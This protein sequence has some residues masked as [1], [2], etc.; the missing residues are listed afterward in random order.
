MKNYRLH[1]IMVLGSI[2]A[3]SCKN[4]N[5]PLEEGSWA[6]DSFGNKIEAWFELDST[7]IGRS[8]IRQNLDVPWE[9]TWGPDNNI[10]FT[11]QGGRVSRLNPE[12]GEVQVL[13]EI[14]EVFRKRTT[15]LLGMAIH[16][17]FQNNPHVFLNYTERRKGTI[18]SRLV[19][20]EYL[21]DTLVNPRKLLEI[22][23]H[24]AHN[25]SRL[26][27]SPDHKLI[28]ATGDIG[29][30]VD[31]AQNLNSLNGKLLRLNLD[32]TIPP[33]NPIPGSPVWSW[34]Q[35]NVQGLVYG[36]KG[37]AYTSEHGDAT[38]DEINL[39]VK[40]GNYGWPN[41]SGK[42]N[43]LAENAAFCK[44]SAIID[45]IK[46]WTPTIAPAGIDY[47]FS[48]TIPEWNNSILLVT[49]KES[50]F[51]VLKLNKDGDCIL[52][53]RIFLDNELGRLRDICVS[54]AGDIYI[55]TSNRD[56]NPKEG[57][58]GRS[59]DR[60][61]RVF[62]AGNQ[63]D[64]YLVE[65]VAARKN[66]EADPVSDKNGGE[67]KKYYE[68]YCA[69]CH[70]TNGQGVEN[71]FPSLLSSEMVQGGNDNLIQL[72]M[73]GSSGLRPSLDNSGER[74]PAFD[75]LSDEEIAKIL[76]FAIREFGE[77]EDRITLD[78]VSEGRSAYTD[79]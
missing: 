17:D 41:L 36:G 33:D 11:E 7:I 77:R 39:M 63:T 60:I 69:S 54:P 32:G 72:I 65:Y 59:D 47:Y 26:A 2:M 58:P 13:L 14:P 61:I 74:M 22:P 19:R 62:K 48:H 51:R 76:T 35:R 40:G 44:D 46:S 38:D 12:T 75:F 21:K 25:G 37:L 67:G 34:G 5:P 6:Y 4:E 28:W 1:I 50:D 55:S 16:P 53:E 27:I 31:N 30:N 66:P 64:K 68:M 18:T 42:C 78:D 52:S 79:K 73:Q 10:W 15:G 9:I 70:K 29:P 43:E 71:S 57:F 49:L 24:T 3:I 8:T 23:G 56:W 45:P 20:Y